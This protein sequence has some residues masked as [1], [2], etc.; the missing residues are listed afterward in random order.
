MARHYPLTAF[1]AAEVITEPAAAPAR[2]PF[3]RRAYK[4]MVA[5]QQRRAERE[6]AFYIEQ[7][8]GRLTDSLEREIADR[9]WAR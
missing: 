3:W 6:V 9:F 2:V 7:H 1:E 5:A 8:G 4:A